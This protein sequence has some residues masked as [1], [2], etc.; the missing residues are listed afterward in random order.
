M[1]KLHL[2]SAMTW[3]MLALCLPVMAED[4]VMHVH[5]VKGDTLDVMIPET[6]TASWY[7]NTEKYPESVFYAYTGQTTLDDEG[8]A[9]PLVVD[10]E[11]RGFIL[12]EI[13]MIN[14]SEI[15]F[16]LPSAGVDNVTSDNLAVSISDGIMCISSVTEPVHIIIAAMSGVVEYDSII[17]SDTEIDMNRFGSGVHTIAV[18]NLNFKILVK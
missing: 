10:G 1:R 2:K 5:T 18:S 15:T 6:A 3:A 13:P 14:I 16:T 17:D 12:C 7:G 11:I 9:I 8:R 4:C